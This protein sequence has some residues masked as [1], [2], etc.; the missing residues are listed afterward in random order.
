[1]LRRV[2]KQGSIAFSGRLAL[3]NSVQIPRSAARSLCII[4]MIVLNV[5]LIDIQSGVEKL[6]LILSVTPDR[7]AK[8]IP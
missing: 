2:P 7:K 4:S 8:V 1:M 5:S 6:I 3:G